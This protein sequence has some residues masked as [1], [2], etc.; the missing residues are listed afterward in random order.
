[1]DCYEYLTDEE[2]LCSDHRRVIEQ[3][4]FTYPLLGKLLKNSQMRLKSKEKNK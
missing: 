2:T 4:N 3:A 1:M